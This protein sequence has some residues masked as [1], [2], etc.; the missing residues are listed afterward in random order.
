MLLVARKSPSPKK[1][2][3]KIEIRFFDFEQKK[4]T[5]NQWK[6]KENNTPQLEI[7]NFNYITGNK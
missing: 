4:E 7:R 1:K 6:K 3:L 2:I 5:R